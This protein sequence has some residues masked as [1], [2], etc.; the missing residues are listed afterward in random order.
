MA[1]ID[2]RSKVPISAVNREWLQERE[3]KMQRCLCHISAMLSFAWFWGVYWHH[4]DKQEWEV[5]GRTKPCE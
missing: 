3:S 5:R 4:R 1:C 2:S